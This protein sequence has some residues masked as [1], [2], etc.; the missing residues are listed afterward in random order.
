MDI[1]LKIVGFNYGDKGTKNEHVISSFN[2]ESSDGLV[3]T[4]PQGLTEAKMLDV[5][6]RQSELLGKIIQVTCNGLSSNSKGEYS[7]MYPRFT[8]ERSDKNT[9][10]SLES[11]KEIANNFHHFLSENIDKK[12]EHYKKVFKNSVIGY[13]SKAQQEI[14]DI[15][16]ND[17][18]E[19]DG[20][21]SGMRVDI[22]NK[23]KKRKLL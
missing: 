23:E 3:K 7:L 22:I 18:Y 11:I 20:Y 16:K 21:I 12:T 6:K 14:Y 2:C 8:S 19:I 17:G 15:L 4:R 1:D 5:T 9:C 10:D 13:I